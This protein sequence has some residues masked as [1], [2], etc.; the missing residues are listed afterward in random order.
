MNAMSSISKC[1]VKSCIC[2]KYL[3]CKTTVISTANN[4]QISV[5]NNSDLDCKSNDVIAYTLGIEIFRFAQHPP[6]KRF[7]TGF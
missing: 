6:H 2:C 3:N 5:V 1:N 4:R 7:D